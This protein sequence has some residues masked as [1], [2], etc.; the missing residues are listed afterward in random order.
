MS[1]SVQTGPRSTEGRLEETST[2]AT[3]GLVA[4]VLGLTAIGNGLILYAIDPAALALTAVD[5]VIGVTGLVFYAL[6]NR[7]ALSRIASGR[8][9]AMTVSEILLGIG[10]IG[11]LLGAN[12]FASK[13]TLEADL[14]RDRLYSLREQSV[15]VASRLKTK[16]TVYGFFKPVDNTRVAL[17]QLVELYRNYTPNIEVELINPDSAPPALVRRFQITG[18]G[19]RIVAATE[20]RE[21]KLKTPTEEELTNALVKIAEMPA[22]KVYFLGGHGEPKIDDEKTELGLARAAQGTGDSGFDIADLSL[23]DKEH[24]PGDAAVVVIAG[25]KSPL[26]PNELNAISEYVD[27]GG[28]VLAMLEPGVDSALEPYLK[29]F[30]IEVGDNLVID[31]NPASKALGFGPDAP[32]ITQFEQHP[33]TEPLRD[34]PTP[35]LFYWARSVS[36]I[37]GTKGV[38]VTTLIQS[39]PS[40]WGETKYKKGGDV[41][42][43]E[44]DMP[45]PVPLAVAATKSSITMVNKINDQARI[46]AIG[47]S[48]FATNKFFPRGGNSDLFLHAVEWLVGEEEKI[49]IRPHS[50]AGARLLLTEQQQTGIVFFSVNV[51]PLL[52]IG[53]GFSVWA[54]RRRK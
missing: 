24:V 34:H 26:F 10:V 36:P 15:K 43:D 3:V 8:S 18:T 30:G 7:A 4:G 44:D 29:G 5:G 14:T 37:P 47:D 22:H 21:T 53:L 54:V 16:V 2:I 35:L 39:S 51:L 38:S 13:S 25:P 42:R 28:R 27:R 46:V 19:A 45:G 6:T 17:K 1:D 41:A 40:S 48:S 50:R 9:T 32:V 31:P 23:I 20:D 11:A 49:S 33:V 12:Y 52:I